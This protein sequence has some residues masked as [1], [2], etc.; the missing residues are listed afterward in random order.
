LEQGAACNIPNSDA[1]AVTMSILFDFWGKV[2]PSILQ[3]VS[4]SKVVIP[5]KIIL[6]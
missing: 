1:H 3:L 4:H 5:L 2:T 6:Y